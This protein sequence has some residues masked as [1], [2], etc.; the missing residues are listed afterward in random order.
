MKRILLV[1]GLISGLIFL[2][3]TAALACSCAQ[4][5]TA[6]DA[7]HADSV[8]EGTLAWSTDNRVDMTYGFNVT[9]VYKGQAATFEKLRTD[10]NST[11]CGLENPVTGQHY[12]FFVQGM[13]PGQ[14]KVNRCGG[15]AVYSYALAAQVQSA[16]GPGADPIQASSP[17]VEAGDTGL[18]TFGWVVLG[19]GAVVI[20]ALSVI[21][22]R[23]KFR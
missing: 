13:H 23:T 18:G 21:A 6:A 11:P 17:I 16:T 2:M 14:M 8:F 7:K 22:L 3:P 19:G 10:P 20:A 4:S 1:V 5:S 15:S 12:L 9:K